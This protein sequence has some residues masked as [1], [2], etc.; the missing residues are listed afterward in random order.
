MKQQNIFKNTFKLLIPAFLLLTF[1]I[2]LFAQ[3]KVAVNGNDVG[4]WFGKNWMWVTGA[5]LFLLLLLL[6]S[7]GSKKT[8]TTTPANYN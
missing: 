2:Q 7:G 5:I 4:T 1:N 3:Q 8:K 6:F